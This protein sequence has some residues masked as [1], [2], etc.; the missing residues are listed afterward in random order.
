MYL[1][2]FRDRSQRRT[3]RIVNISENNVAT[4]RE[5]MQ[6]IIIFVYLHSP[7]NC[8]KPRGQYTREID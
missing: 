7:L 2:V 4:L 8:D 3:M 6:T 5:K 1:E